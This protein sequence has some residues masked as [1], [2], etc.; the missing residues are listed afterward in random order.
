M[1]LPKEVKGLHNY[2]AKAGIW[3]LFV[4]FIRGSGVRV[5]ELLVS[6]SHLDAYNFFQ[7]GYVCGRRAIYPVLKALPITRNR[8]VQ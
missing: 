7:S 6:L 3:L 4:K 5:Q 1:S 2:D 8:V